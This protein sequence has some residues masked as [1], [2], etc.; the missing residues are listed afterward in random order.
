MLPSEV[1]HAVRENEADNGDAKRRSQVDGSMAPGIISGPTG[2]RRLLCGRRLKSLLCAGQELWCDRHERILYS[3]K[4][5]KR[6]R[7]GRHEQYRGKC[8]K[9]CLSRR[10]VLRSMTWQQGIEQT[11]GT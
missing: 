3:P 4:A 5:V 8:E 9:G 7:R 2:N 11:R 6:G 1:A 10:D